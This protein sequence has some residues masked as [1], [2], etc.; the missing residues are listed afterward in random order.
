MLDN[1]I[2][3]YCILALIVLVAATLAPG[4][5]SPPSD[6]GDADGDID[7]DGDADGDRDTGG[8]A[9]AD[10]DGDADIDADAD[11]DADSD[12]DSPEEVDGSGEYDASGSDSGCGDDCTDELP[13]G[14]LSDEICGNGSDDDCDREVDEGCPCEPGAVQGCFVGPP[15]YRNHGVCTDGHQICQGMEFGAWGPC[16]GGIWPMTEV[17]DLAD[18]DC[19]GCIDEDL[20]CDGELD[21]PEPDDPRVPDTTPFSDYLLRGADFYSGDATAWSWEVHGPPCD[22]MRERTGSAARSYT[23]TGADGPELTIRFT[24]SGDYTVVLRVTTPGGEVLECTFVVHV[25]GPGLR[26]ELCWDRVGGVFHTDLDLHLHRPGSTSD[27]FGEILGS[28]EQTVSG[29]DCY[30]CNCKASTFCTGA[31]E[32]DWGYP[33]TPLENCVNG[34]AGAQWRRRGGCRNPR[35]DIDNM[36][37]MDGAK[38]E[39]INVDNPADGDPFRV[40][41]HYFGGTRETH[42]I[43]NVYCGGFLVGTYGDLPDELPGFRGPGEQGWGLGQM[44]RVADI[45]TRVAGDDMTCELTPLRDPAAPASYWITESD[46]SY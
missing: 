39:N 13:L 35:L 1:M 4:A 36:S 33:D 8:D 18:N 22:L 6:A 37:M 38:P 9:D 31:T 19:N 43:V 2:F 15:G 23:L 29:D 11:T 27:W 5:C 41:V 25:R 30:Y 7:V 32:P 24:L 28:G 3:R 34:P 17:C 21:C 45:T 12:H 42:P 20:C 10:G 44:W 46:R 16:E 26:I 14:C 40:M